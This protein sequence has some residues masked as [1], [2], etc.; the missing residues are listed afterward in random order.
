MRSGSQGHPESYKLNDSGPNPMARGQV[1]PNPVD[2]K[3][4]YL[5]PHLAMPQAAGSF[6]MDLGAGHLHLCSLQRAVTWT[7]VTGLQTPENNPRLGIPETF[8]FFL[9]LVSLSFHCFCCECEHCFQFFS[10]V[11]LLRF[12]LLSSL[13]CQLPRLGYSSLVLASNLFSSFIPLFFPLIAFICSCLRV[14]SLY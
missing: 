1:N 12:F 8:L 9:S 11:L 6:S 5:A 4:L 14:K 10:F 13:L 7:G 2:L 3:V